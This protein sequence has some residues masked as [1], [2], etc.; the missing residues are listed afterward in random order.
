MNPQKAVPIAAVHRTK[1]TIRIIATT[2]AGQTPTARANLFNAAANK[3]PI[4][5]AASRPRITFNKTEKFLAELNTSD[6]TTTCGSKKSFPMKPRALPSAK[7][8]STARACP[9][10]P[11]HK[12]VKVIPVRNKE[13]LLPTQRCKSNCRLLP[14]RNNNR[15]FGNNDHLR[16]R[17]VI[18]PLNR[19]QK[20]NVSTKINNNTNTSTNAG[21]REKEKPYVLGKQI[22]QGAYAVVKEGI[23]KTNNCKVAIKVYEKYKLLDAQRKKC[24]TR[25][26]AILKK[27]SHPNIVHFYE[28]VDNPKQM[29]LVFELIKGKSLCSYVRSKDGKK[30]DDKEAR[31]VFT[32]VVS[33]IEYCHSLGILHRD[34]K[35]DN[36]LIDE[37][38]NVKVID[39]G[40][41]TIEQPNTQL[42]SFCGTPS[43]MAPE[44]VLKKPY[45]GKPADVWA[46]GILLYALVTGKFPFKGISDKDLYRKIAKGVFTFPNG[47][48]VQAKELI[49]KMLRVDPTKRPN[50]KEILRDQFLL[51][52]KDGVAHR[53]Y[54]IE[55]IDK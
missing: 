10:S 35:L 42:K 11:F 29:Y 6:E 45:N 4:R 2:F 43:Y 46:L 33:G 36:I 50:C 34:V 39:F 52:S 22:G 31:N 48:S 5:K 30:L 18:S 9:S 28:V 54:L 38:H 7:S 55:K 12:A 37:S 41:A 15:I 32:Q 20:I 47:V 13:N 23:N 16:L 44:I 40:F 3:P 49:E 27:I 21:V 19:T 24:V 53:P 51:G 26:V 8:P 14:T 25:E 1:N 17:G